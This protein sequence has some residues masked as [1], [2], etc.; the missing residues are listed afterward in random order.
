M[1]TG[2]IE[3]AGRLLRRQTSGSAGKLT[4]KTDLPMEQIK[5]GESIAVN[6]ACLTVENVVPTENA[7]VFHTLRETLER[8]NLGGLESGAMVNLERALQPG[9]RLGGH[10]VLGHVDAVAEITEIQKKNDDIVVQ[11]SLPQSLNRLMIEK[12]SI[13][14]DGISLTVAEL[15]SASFTVH[16]IP[17][18]WEHTNL[19]SAAAGTRVNLEADMLGK[20]VLRAVDG[21][22]KDE[23]GLK[24][25]DLAESGF[26]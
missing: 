22:T 23:H 5:L 2:L 14:V 3:S 4:I 7:M 21:L 11:I 19:F 25:Q 8:T 1:F 17:H 13:A 24:M 16:V 18:T 9:D 10:F 6:G 12:G 20:Y 15:R 26:L